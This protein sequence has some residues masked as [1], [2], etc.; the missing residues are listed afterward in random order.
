MTLNKIKLLTVLLIVAVFTGGWV[1]HKFYVSL[2]EIRYNP[3]SSRFEIS[4]RIFPDD[5]DRGFLRIYGVQTH[6]ATELEYASA[7][8]LI[9]SYLRVHFDVVVDEIQL[10]MDFLG[11]EPEADAIW[12]YIESEPVKNPRTLQIRNSVLTD[13]FEGQVNIIQVYSGKWNRGLLLNRQ[14]IS[15][16]LTIGQ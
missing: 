7:D 1:L 14:E 10:K 9:E 12:C 6:M 4:M 8:S 16:K 13:E 3:A 2:T 5:L 15:G 11:K